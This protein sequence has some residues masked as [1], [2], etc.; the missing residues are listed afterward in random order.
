MLKTSSLTASRKC[1]QN[2][3][4][5]LWFSEEKKNAT[6]LKE[7]VEIWGGVQIRQMWIRPRELYCNCDGYGG[8]EAWHIQKCKKQKIGNLWNSVRN[9]S[10]FDSEFKNFENMFPWGKDATGVGLGQSSPLWRGWVR[11]G[12]DL[13]ITQRRT[14]RALEDK[15]TW[16]AL[17]EVVAFAAKLRLRC[18]YSQGLVTGCGTVFQLNSTPPNSTQPNWAALSSTQLHST[19]LGSHTTRSHKT[20]CVCNALKEVKTNDWS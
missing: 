12:S 14:C 16:A 4:K 19:Q 15:M 10:W 20:R 13:C 7:H 5:F 6:N 11:H 18:S 1:I 2:I 3:R 8:V 9:V 17:D